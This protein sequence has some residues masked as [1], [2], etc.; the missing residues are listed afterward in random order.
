M[1]QSCYTFILK[2]L[3]SKDPLKEQLFTLEPMRSF[4]PFI[5]LPSP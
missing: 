4:D 5:D 1:L 2:F 3:L